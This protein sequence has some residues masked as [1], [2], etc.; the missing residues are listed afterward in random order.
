MHLCCRERTL[1]YLND[2]DGRGAPGRA[3]RRARQRLGLPRDS[4][5]RNWFPYLMV[6]PALSSCLPSSST[7][8][9]TRST[10]H[11]PRSTCCDP[12]RRP[13]SCSRTCSTT[14]RDWRRDDVF[15]RR[16][17]EHH[18]LHG[19]DGECLAHHRFRDGHD[20]GTHDV[21]LRSRTRA[22]DDPDDVRASPH[23]LPVLVVLQ[24]HGRTRQ[25]RPDH[26]RAHQPSPSPGSWWSPT[27]CSPSWWRPSG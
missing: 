24:C 13:S 20:A 15:W 10:S 7:R 1:E 11:S 23:R 6:L 4:R 17:L 8:W 19:R 9:R 26:A 2:D 22:A 25:Q 3:H 18:P 12:T 16:S 5:R 27:A 21:R 14:T